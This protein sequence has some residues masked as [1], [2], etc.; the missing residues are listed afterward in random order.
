MVNDQAT[1]AA[2]HSSVFTSKISPEK[3][4]ETVFNIQALGG[5]SKVH[6]LM[7]V[8]IGLLQRLVGVF[9]GAARPFAQLLTNH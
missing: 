5:S 9:P 4:A 8:G 6:F 7:D 3:V 1:P 2:V